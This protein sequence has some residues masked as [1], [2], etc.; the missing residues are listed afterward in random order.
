MNLEV[1]IQHSRLEFFDTREDWIV[2]QKACRLRPQ[3]QG[4]I[5]FELVNHRVAP[6]AVD[7]ASH[8]PAL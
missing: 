1:T 5:K 7:L 6:F 4:N 8:V 3:G 2:R